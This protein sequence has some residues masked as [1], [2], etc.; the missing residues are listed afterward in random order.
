MNKIL[1]IVDGN[2]NQFQLNSFQSKINE[3]STKEKA[4]N[5]FLMDEG[6][7]LLSDPF[8]EKVY[9]PK[10]LYYANVIDV[11]RFHVSFQSEVIFSSPKTLKQL[12]ENADKVFHYNGN[13]N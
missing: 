11:D 4:L 7:L 12:I 6:V 8:W 1:L 5:I 9:S 13:G 2:P 10:V 3:L